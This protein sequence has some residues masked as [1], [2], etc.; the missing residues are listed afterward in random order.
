MSKVSIEQFIAN[1]VNTNGR[2]CPKGVLQF[3]G[4]FTANDID[5]AVNG[6][7]IEA[8]RGPQ[9]GFFI[10]GTKPAPQND[11]PVTLKSRLVDTLR[12][13][14]GGGVVLP[15]QIDSLLKEYEQECTKRSMAK[16]KK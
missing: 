15:S 9:G 6:G 7:L 1:Y 14:R 3:V 12:T 5:N 11:S 4:G 10:R 13:I 2:G 16:R 8:A